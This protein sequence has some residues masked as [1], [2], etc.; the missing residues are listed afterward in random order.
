[1]TKLEIEKEISKLRGES[2]IWTQDVNWPILLRELP[3][4]EAFKYQYSEV[5]NCNGIKASTI[6]DA[7]CG[8]WLKWKM[9]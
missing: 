6:E 1:M 3:H 2:K 7:I 8:A 9:K 4:P 5:W